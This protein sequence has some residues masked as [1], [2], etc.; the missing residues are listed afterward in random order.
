MRLASRLAALALG[1]ALA[2]AAA[3]GG[4]RAAPAAAIEVTPGAGALQAALDAA[5]PGA[6]L[7]LAP[8]VYPGP[9]VIG[10]TLTLEGAP[11]AILDGGGRGRVLSVAAPDV[12]VRGLTV[13]NSGLSLAETDA[14]IFLDK[15]ASGA[16][17]EGNRLENNLFGIYLHG[18][19]DALVRGNEVIGNRTL[20]M[21]ERGNG[22]HL[23]A[24][25]GSAV[26]GNRVRYGRDGIFVTASRSNA[27]RNNSF[28]D[29]RFA[30]HYMY[31]HDS[32]VSGNRSRGNHVG[33]ALMYS[34]RLRVF[35]NRS[36][37][38]R[39]HG[40]LFNFTNKSRIEGNL[41]RAGR[42]KC[43]FLYNA[44][45]NLLAG[46]R[47]EGC[48]IGIH[49]TA[50]SEGNRIAG[51]GFLGNATQVKYVGTRHV[52]WSDGGVGNYWSDNP[53]LDLDGDGIGDVPYRPNDLVDQVVWRHPLAKLLLTSPSVRILRWAHDR[54]PSVYP[55]G[56]V[57]S[58]P[59]MR[60]PAL[61]VG[62]GRWR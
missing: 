56:V 15:A 17:V 61:A 18:A 40:F 26:E 54:F 36:V 4:A 59:L 35:G 47:F 25:R 45:R 58:A 60:P 55:G 33:Y 48:A 29:L 5:A 12:A 3:A 39:D 20:R 11:G 62:A 44:N 32:E 28:S 2:L 7:R 50:G 43:V 49:F 14:G 6:L 30:I 16:L 13:R 52:E 9:V 38:D 8:G 27:F 19:R 10:R 57:D 34:D 21:S 1:A 22:I 41:V 24:A 51:N 37:G 23:W 46:N 42:T 31:T 53:A